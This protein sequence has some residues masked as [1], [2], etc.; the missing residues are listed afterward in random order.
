VFQALLWDARLNPSRIYV[1]TNNGIVTLR[2]RIQELHE[3]NIREN[4]TK[5]VD[6]KV[7]NG[8]VLLTGRVKNYI[9]KIYAETLANMV[10]NVSYVQNK[11]IISKQKNNF[12]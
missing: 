11:L 12:K 9:T 5:D 3:Q 8:I 4:D 7:E 1:Q 2:R 6:V 10:A